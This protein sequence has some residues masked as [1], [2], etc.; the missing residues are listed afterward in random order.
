MLEP[1]QIKQIKQFFLV[2]LKSFTKLYYKLYKKLE[3][4]LLLATPTLV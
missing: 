4:L 3:H 1:T 2:V